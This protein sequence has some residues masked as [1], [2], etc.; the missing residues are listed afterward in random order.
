MA[1]CKCNRL[2]YAEVVKLDPE[3][4]D[5][6]N[7]LGLLRTRVGDLDGAIAAFERVLALSNK[8]KDK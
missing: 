4:P 1:A 3:D 8:T 6:W 2:G 5:G 7:M